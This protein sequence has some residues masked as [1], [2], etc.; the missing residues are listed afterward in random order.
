MRIIL[1]A[2]TTLALVSCGTNGEGTP[3]QGEPGESTT[4]LGER[5]VPGY[6]LRATKLANGVGGAITVRVQIIAEAG[7]PLP[8]TVQGWI[9]GDYDPQAVAL[10]AR[11]VA[12]TSDQFDVALALPQP[13]PEGAAVWVRLILPDGTALEVGRSAF[14]I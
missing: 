8:A 10:E 2:V 12:G 9:G 3:A 6:T 1:M 7:E 13:L 11:P 5:S 4:A 14:P